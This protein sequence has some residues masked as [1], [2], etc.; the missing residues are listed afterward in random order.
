MKPLYGHSQRH[1]ITLI[2]YR[3]DLKELALINHLGEEG[4]I[5]INWDELLLQ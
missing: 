3:D 1:K 4:Y 2:Y 5:S